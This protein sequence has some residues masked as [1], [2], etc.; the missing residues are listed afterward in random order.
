[1]TMID[2]DTLLQDID[3]AAPCGPNLEYEADFLALERAV[4]GT[5]EIQYGASITAA[6][7]PDW[8]V[9]WVLASG[10]F[11]RS[12]DLR[13]AVPLL[14][15]ALALQ[16]LTGLRDGLGLIERL[17]EE[18]WEDMHPLLDPEDDLDPMMRINALAMLA[19][20]ATVLHEVKETT[21]FDL[22]GLGPLNLRGL[23]IGSDER[24]SSQGPVKIS[25]TSITGALAKIDVALL[26]EMIE[27][28]DLALRSTLR[29]ETILMA[30]VGSA[31]A[32]NL[33]GLSSSLK[34]GRDFFQE[35]VALHS[36][37][38]RVAQGGAGSAGLAGPNLGQISSVEEVVFM[39]DKILGYYQ[40][41]EPSSPVPLLLERSKRLVSMNFL[42]LMEELTP[43]GMSQLM[44]ISG[45]Q[46]VPE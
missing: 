8:K 6:V 9:I 30:H 39:L 27:T 18:R 14:R 25:V 46:R 24:A 11:A 36:T 7:A 32:L 26:L 23:E 42:Q 21:L 33:D 38:E 15:C 17:I 34:R 29:I 45:L 41:Y 31:Q 13:L 19:D 37:S 20:A 44:V 3:D 10:L 5:P 22:S 12:R 1:M 35:Q 43:D 28:M 16:G 40:R 4:A 2:I